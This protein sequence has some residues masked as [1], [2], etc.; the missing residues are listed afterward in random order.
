MSKTLIQ[1]KDKIKTI[2]QNHRQIN[3]YGDEKIWNVNTSG[4]VNYPT[5]WSVY[6]STELRK[7]EKGYRFEFYCLDLIQKGRENINDI[8]SDTERTISDVL[9]EL[10]W[11]GDADIDLKVESFNMESIDED[12]QDDEVAGHKCNVTIWTDFK[13]NSCTIPTIT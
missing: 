6:Q 4:T 7:G 11:G 9:A 8:H 10:E 1:I 3:F 5:F 2:A 12:F 13:L